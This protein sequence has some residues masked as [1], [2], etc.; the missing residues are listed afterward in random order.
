MSE[1]RERV[2]HNNTASQIGAKEVR[3]ASDEPVSNSRAAG[4]RAKPQVN[5]REILKT[6]YCTFSMLKLNTSQAQYRIHTSSLDKPEWIKTNKTQST[7]AHEHLKS[8]S[9]PGTSVRDKPR[10]FRLKPSVSPSSEGQDLALKI[11]PKIRLKLL[12]HNPSSSSNPRP[13]CKLGPK[14][15][16]SPNS[17]LG[18]LAP[19]LRHNIS[20][21]ET[22]AHHTSRHPSPSR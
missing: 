17:Q 18:S 20:Q 14:P 11:R 13:A 5:A 3:H 7:Q 8:Q 16:P 1:E 19:K 12:M 15:R 6:P 4:A 10:G 22:I 2:S 21:E 9:K